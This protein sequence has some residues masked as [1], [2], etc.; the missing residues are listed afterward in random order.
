MT[1]RATSTI[2]R[3]AALFTLA[4]VAACATAP[5][6]PIP[7]APSP[8]FE[9][10]APPEPPAAAAPSPAVAKPVE[11][12]PAPTVA[13]VVTAPATTVTARITSHHRHV[14]VRRHPGPHGRPVAVLRGG[15]PVTVVAKEGKWVKIRWEHRG[16]ARE[17]WVY[18]KYVEEGR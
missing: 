18:G 2:I 9:A 4:L 6:A 12:A 1:Q 7:Q 5:E 8:P 14:N 17:G 16:K 15:S 10:E 11:P 3:S 13:V